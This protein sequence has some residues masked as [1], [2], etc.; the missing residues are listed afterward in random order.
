MIILA[1]DTSSPV[2]SA[3]I[4]SDGKLV[5]EYVI[6]NGKTHSQIIIPLISDML[7]KS[8]VAIEDIDVFATSLGPGSFTGLR[9]GVSTAKSFAQAMNKE[10]IGISALAGLSANITYPEDV[11]ICPI[12]DARR[13]NVYN[14]VYRNGT[15]IKEDRL[16]SLD[17]LLNEISEKKT[18]FLGDGIIKH[19]EKIKSAMGDNVIFPPEHIAMQRASSIAY[20]ANIRATNGDFDNLHSMEPIYVRASQAERELVGEKD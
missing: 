11:L 5:G 8:G 18:L 12:M 16:I 20:L 1:I 6:S 14:A 4:M 10:I 9:I 7:N 17:D 3:A 2:A 19:R 13:G 15:T